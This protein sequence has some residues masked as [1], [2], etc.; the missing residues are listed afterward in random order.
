MRGMPDLSASFRSVFVR[1]NLKYSASVRYRVIVYTG[2]VWGAN[3]GEKRGRVYVR[4][5]E[6]GRDIRVL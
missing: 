3:K 2:R 6:A 1:V 4:L 5:G